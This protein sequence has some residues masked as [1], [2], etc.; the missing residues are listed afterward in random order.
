MESLK[1]KNR[2]PEIQNYL[3]HIN[4]RLDTEHREKWKLIEYMQMEGKSFKKMR[5]KTDIIPSNGQ[6]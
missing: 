5:K 4:R 2:T 1:V 3:G 6:A